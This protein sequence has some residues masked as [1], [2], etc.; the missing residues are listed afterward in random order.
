MTD[1][2]YS[3]AG[4]PDYST[5]FCSYGC[6]G[7]GTKQYCCKI[8]VGVIIGAIF[9]GLALLSILVSVI[10]CFIKHKTT[11]GRVVAPGHNNANL[12][13]STVV[14][15]GGQAMIQTYG[16][17]PGEHSGA[18]Y[19]PPGYPAGPPAYKEVDGPPPAYTYF[20]P[21]SG[22]APAPASSKPNPAAPSAL[23]SAEPGRAFASSSPEGNGAPPQST[24]NPHA[25]SAKTAFM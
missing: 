14:Y 24:K 12:Y 5:T 7:Y 4:K 18:P 1:F 11:S 10:C 22:L 20:S 25:V 13:A 23:P 9:A 3:W 19:L 16:V 2:H 6:C 15:A 17:Q 8:T 21:G